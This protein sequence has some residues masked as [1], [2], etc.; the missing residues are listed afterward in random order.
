MP[1][2]LTPTTELLD[3]E[4]VL[5]SFQGERANYIRT[6]TWIAAGAMAVGMGIL[7]AVGNPYVWTGAV[8]GLAAVAVRAGYLMSDELAVRW[9]LTTQRLLGPGGRA[10]SLSNIAELNKLG[11][12]MQVVTKTGDKHLIKYQADPQATMAAIERVM[13]GATT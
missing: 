13:N 7:W 5:D 6:N 4:A 3:G 1:D 10:I 12:F 11:S 8:G 2:L 9:D